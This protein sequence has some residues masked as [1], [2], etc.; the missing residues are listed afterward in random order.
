MSL[1][2]GD[3]FAFEFQVTAADGA[4]TDADSAPTGTVVRNGDDDATPTVTIANKATGRYK[5]SGTVPSGYAAGDVV[6]VRLAATVGGVAT[7]GVQPLGVLDS[8]RVGEVSAQLAQQVA[9]EGTI[10][11]GAAAGATSLTLPTG[12]AIAAGSLLL[13]QGTARAAAYV[14][15]YTSGTGATTLRDPGLSAA[16]ADGEDFVAYQ[17]A[18]VPS[19]ELGSDGRTLVSADAHTAGATIAGIAGTKNTL[20][21]LNDLSAAQVRSN[22]GEDARQGF[23]R[24]VVS[25]TWLRNLMGATDEDAPRISQASRVMAPPRGR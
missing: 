3:A 21:D 24:M 13:F 10:T 1:R 25:G 19:L 8:A 16:V 11:T 23:D 17:A 14:E 4:L 7:G 20:D 15:A 18:D 12:L 22:Q 9:D 6:Q 2:P 5:A